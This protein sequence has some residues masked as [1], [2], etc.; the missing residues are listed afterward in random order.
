[1]TTP[2]LPP[3]PIDNPLTQRDGLAS[4]PWARWLQQLWDDSRAVYAEYTTNVHALAD[5]THVRFN[6][7]TKV[8]DTHD[9]VTVGASWKFTAP[10]TRIYKVAS[11]M[12]LNANAVEHTILSSLFWNGSGVF[13][14]HRQGFR[15]VKPATAGL[16][17]V[18]F[19]GLIE[20][21]V[22]QA[23]YLSFFQ[24]SGGSLNA[25]TAHPANWIAIAE[26]GRTA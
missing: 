17:S 6:F 16:F 23:I 24:N 9:A 8:K 11:R 4:P 7:A 10:K 21:Q 1:M 2:S 25:E 12:C 14:E 22:G 13:V 18:E 5:S 19:A 15:T 20:L 3:P 26:A